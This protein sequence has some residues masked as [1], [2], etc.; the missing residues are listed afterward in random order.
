MKVVIGE[1]VFD[2]RDVPIVIVMD[3][4]DKKNLRNMDSKANKYC[5][6]PDATLLQ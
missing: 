2:A 1:E 4:D 5:A 6:Y 3:E